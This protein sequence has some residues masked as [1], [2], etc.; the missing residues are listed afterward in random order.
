LPFTVNVQAEKIFPEAQDAQTTLAEFKVR[1]SDIDQNNHV[2]NTKYSQWVL[3]A[4]PFELHRDHQIQSYS[5]NFLAE[6]KLGDV[7]KI[8]KGPRQYSDESFFKTQFQG[9]RA[10][11]SKIMFLTEIEVKKI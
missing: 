1:N 10:S 9:L 11:D 7:V 4:V 5:I 6:T 2:N 8:Q 3:D